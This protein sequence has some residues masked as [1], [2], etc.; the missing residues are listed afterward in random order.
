LARYKEYMEAAGVTKHSVRNKLR[1]VED[2]YVEDGHV[3]SFNG[4]IL[5]SYDVCGGC[6]AHAILYALRHGLA[7]S[8]ATAPTLDELTSS[9]RYGNVDFINCP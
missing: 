1:D 7:E 9:Q 3:F 4:E 2:K 8:V 5:Y 6:E